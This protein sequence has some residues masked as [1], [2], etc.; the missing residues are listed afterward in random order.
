MWPTR[1]NY[2]NWFF[3]IADQLIMPEYIGWD[4]RGKV[5]SWFEWFGGF[6][7][8]N[9]Y[10]LQLDFYNSN[11]WMCRVSTVRR[12]LLCR[13]T[14]PTLFVAPRR[15]SIITPSPTTPKPISSPSHTCR[16][17]ALKWDLEPIPKKM[18]LGMVAIDRREMFWHRL[19]GL[20]KTKLHNFREKIK[21]LEIATSR[22]NKST[23]LPEKENR[24]KRWNWRR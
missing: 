7:D 19:W 9:G 16:T 6:I 11:L 13:S 23:I 10:G 1:R 15:E 20:F 5:W 22:H 14:W 4:G 18:L 12:I 2:S 3:K 17:I 21:S 24:R 8:G